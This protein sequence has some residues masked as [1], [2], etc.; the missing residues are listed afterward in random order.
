MKKGRDDEP[1]DK[2]FRVWSNSF[3][4]SSH[5]EY[6]Y[7]CMTCGTLIHQ[8]GDNAPFWNKI[9]KIPEG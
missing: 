8:M 7:R 1:H 6:I 4:G 2:L 9:D 5:E 3:R